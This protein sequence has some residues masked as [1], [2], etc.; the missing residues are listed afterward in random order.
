MRLETDSVMPPSSTSTVSR[1]SP[2]LMRAGSSKRTA[3]SPRASV[4]TSTLGSAWPSSWMLAVSAWLPSTSPVG[5]LT[6]M[7][8]TTVSPG[9]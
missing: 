9:P 8:A 4:V 2:R 3:A 5:R 6:L 7:L 1:P